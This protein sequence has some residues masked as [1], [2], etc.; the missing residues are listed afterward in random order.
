MKTRSE[1]IREEM[2]RSG[3]SRDMQDKDHANALLTP[4]E[5][6]ERALSDMLNGWMRYADAWNRR[7][8]A[9]IA[10]QP[11]FASDIWMDIG[12]SIRDLLQIE[13]GRFSAGGLD[14]L[15]VDTMRN[16][17]GDPETMSFGDVDQSTR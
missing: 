3:Q 11:A 8:G 6:F 14:N 7:F 1:L 10:D 15:I 17:G 2:E 16:H 12:Q 4:R 9:P 13:T 5:G